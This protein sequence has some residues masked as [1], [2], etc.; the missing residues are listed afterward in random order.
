MDK[1]ITLFSPAKINVFFFVLKKRN[2]GF[3][4]IASLM[5]ATSLCD[6]LH[7]T[8]GSEDC[9]T[10]SD[11]SLR[12]DE[13]NLIMQAVSLFREKTKTFFP[14]KI[15]L[16]KNIPKEAGLGGGSSNLATTLWALNQF[17]E[18]PR[19]IETLKNWASLISS[20]APFFFSSGTA[21][22]TGRGE[23]IQDIQPSVCLSP[24]WLAKPS[25][26]LKTPE[27]YRNFKPENF[28]DI[29]DPYQV[30]KKVRKTPSE[31]INDL[32]SAAFTLK[33]KLKEV[34]KDLFNLGF[35]HVLMTG[36]GTTFYCLGSV[37]APT[38]K[39][40]SFY[41]ITFISRPSGSWYCS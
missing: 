39:N 1:R 27:V 11:P 29:K 7:F 10:C 31:A 4:E 35:K 28:N 2:D 8:K 14:I 36:S 9:L 5:Q 13:S 41:P 24:L 15:H 22:A 21:Y 20:D 6:S 40:V 26:E 16:K 12:C 38:L 25:F 17:L 3:H 30:I 32:E 19:P 37:V 18:D 33:P 34:K 23:N